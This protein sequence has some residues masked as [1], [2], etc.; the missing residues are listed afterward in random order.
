MT[1]EEAF[2]NLKGWAKAFGYPVEEARFA[3]WPEE[4]EVGTRGLFSRERMNSTTGLIWISPGLPPEERTKVL[5][6]ELGHMALFLLKVEPYQRLTHEP[7]A[8][9][10]GQAFIAIQNEDFQNP[11]F[12]MTRISETV[13][14]FL[15]LLKLKIEHTGLNLVRM[16]AEY[17]RWKKEVEEAGKQ[18]GDGI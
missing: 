9:L 16:D 11:L 6:H 13:V 10:L 15:K 14:E 17:F 3:E 2:E 1:H 12:K 8:D 4:L 5:A 7:V 18:D